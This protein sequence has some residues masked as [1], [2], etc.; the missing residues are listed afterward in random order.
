MT[1]LI[2]VIMVVFVGLASKNP[3]RSK[4]LNWIYKTCMYAVPCCLMI[5][6]MFLYYGLS[7]GFSSIAIGKNTIVLFEEYEKGSVGPGE[8]VCRIHI[9]NKETG[10]KTKRIHAGSHDRQ[11]GIKGDSIC[12]QDDNGVVMYDAS[13]LKELW[14]I[15][16]TDWGKQYPELNGGIES[17]NDNNNYDDPRIPC[18]TIAAKNG[19]Q[20]WLDPF[21]KKLMLKEPLNLKK[22]GFYSRGYEIKYQDTSGKSFTVVDQDYVDG[23]KRKKLVTGEH[24]PVKITLTESGTFLDPTFLGIDTAAKVFVFVHYANTDK[25]YFTI[26]AK[27]FSGKTKWKRTGPDLNAVDSYT[28]KSEIDVYALEKGILYLNSGG[29]VLAIKTTTGKIKWKTRL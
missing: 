24:S 14:S 29:Y 3:F 26:E 6:P 27:D 11:I 15:N 22:A 23:S 28:N 4:N 20:Y 13:L 7:D 8:N 10:V 18:L 16:K 5:S 9:L 21:N 17:I 12:Y 1:I 2:L 19:N 25:T